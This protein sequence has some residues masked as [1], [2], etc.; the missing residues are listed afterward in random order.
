ME[1]SSRGAERVAVLVDWNNCR[2][3]AR[4]AF[5]HE[6]CGPEVPWW[7]GAVDPA[8]LASL[9]VRQRPGRTL[10]ATYVFAGEPQR[11]KHPHHWHSFDRLAR[12]WRADGVR[13]VAGPKRK[14]SENANGLQV[15]R[16]KG[17]DIALAIEAL[18]LAFSGAVDGL[19][20]VSAD[21][22]FAPLV[23]ELHPQRPGVAWVELG[24]WRYPGL[25]ARMPDTEYVLRHAL[26]IE[27]FRAIEDAGAVMAD[28]PRPP[29]WE[30]RGDRWEPQFAPPYIGEPAD[31]S[32]TVITTAELAADRAQ[33]AARGRLMQGV[34]RW[35]APPSREHSV[36]PPA[37]AVTRAAQAPPPAPVARAIDSCA[38]G[39]KPGGGS[40]V[41][42]REALPALPP[43]AEEPDPASRDERAGRVP[44]GWWPVR[45]LLSRRQPHP[46]GMAM[47]A[48]TS[49][50]RPCQD[51]QTPAAAARRRSSDVALMGRTDTDPALRER[52]AERARQRS[53]RAQPARAEGARR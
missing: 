46:R 27:D 13:L 1:G 9:L 38:V 11:E 45:L 15:Y 22:D 24:S 41:A 2:W 36:A 44:R 30:V 5:G 3:M 17:V 25:Y 47:P 50:A 21:A 42:A 10:A 18:I 40:P 8:K 37:T 26:T 53:L 14:Y 32:W 49:L 7:F 31:I 28:D 19:I 29:L 39:A 20:L 43:A 34:P 33:A 35:A 51:S 48:A 6:V 12:H 52:R 23:R 4:Y 16:E